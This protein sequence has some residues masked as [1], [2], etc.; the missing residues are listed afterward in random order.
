MY[1]LFFTNRA[2]KDAQLIKASNLKHKVEELLKLISKDPYAYPP[3]FEFLKGEFKGAISRR[4][5][6][7]HR[8][9]YEVLA[10]EQAIKVIM[11]WTHYE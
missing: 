3:E 1:Q 2:K 11:M 9:V 8:L 5:N 6:K 10:K 4:I 7:Q